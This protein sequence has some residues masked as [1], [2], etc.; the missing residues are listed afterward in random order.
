MTNLLRIRFRLPT[1]ARRLRL[2]TLPPMKPPLPSRHPSTPNKS[3]DLIHTLQRPGQ[4]LPH[5]IA[6][7]H[8][9]RH[10]AL[11]R[12]RQSEL[13]RDR[14]PRP[15]PLRLEPVS[16]PPLVRP[17][18]TP[19]L[20]VPPRRRGIVFWGRTPVPSLEQRQIPRHPLIATPRR[21]LRKSPRRSHVPAP[22][23]A[24]RPLPIRLPDP[25]QV[26]ENPIGRRPH[27]RCRPFHFCPPHPCALMS[28]LFCPP[29]IV[30]LM[31][32]WG[33]G[34]C[35][36]PTISRTPAGAAT[37][38]LLRGRSSWGLR[39]GWA[40]CL[41]PSLAVGFG[42]VGCRPG[43]GARRRASCRLGSPRRA[44]VMARVRLAAGPRLSRA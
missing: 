20:H 23:P 17:R 42:A 33:L 5:R 10:V 30:H 39:W 29:F 27:R 16:L 36:D 12:V 11:A 35:G 26:V 14:G 19:Q 13:A 2:P 34:V 37:P 18:P 7:R 43:A 22:R 44:A 8:P 1:P 40:G 21:L 31:G 28:T 24:A 9:H 38:P 3:S 15:P 32:V 25:T 41:N 4:P 6:L